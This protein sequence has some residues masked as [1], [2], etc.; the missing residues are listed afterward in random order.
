MCYVSVLLYST[1]DPI[2]DNK[3]ATDESYNRNADYLLSQNDTF[4]F[5]ATH[6]SGSVEM[7]KKK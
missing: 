3:V 1:T 5:L 2:H 7:A 4:A 6:N